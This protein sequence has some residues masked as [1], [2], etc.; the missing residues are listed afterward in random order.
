M[1]FSLKISSFAS[2]LGSF[3]FFGK[4]IESI[5]SKDE[6]TKGNNFTIKRINR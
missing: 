6:T 3:S 1:W 4:S 2:V 5:E